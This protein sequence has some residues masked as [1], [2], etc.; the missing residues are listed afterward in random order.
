MSTYAAP[1]ELEN[2]A[3]RRLALLGWA[4]A[5]VVNDMREITKPISEVCDSRAYAN[6]YSPTF[7]GDKRVRA[8]E[9]LDNGSFRALVT[10]EGGC[11]RPELFLGA[12]TK[13]VCFVPA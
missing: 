7:A 9:R 10:V 13:L 11:Q 2:A 1:P 8:L 5:W 3:L 6:F 4:W 12:D